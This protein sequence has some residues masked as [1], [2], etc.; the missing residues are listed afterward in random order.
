M[1]IDICIKKDPPQTTPLI[2][3]RS[4]TSK[5]IQILLLQRLHLSAINTNNTNVSADIYDYMYVMF[6]WKLRK[7]QNIAVE[8]R[9]FWLSM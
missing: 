1:F 8:R 4:E 6:Y 2:R 9:F 5:D 7:I 3:H